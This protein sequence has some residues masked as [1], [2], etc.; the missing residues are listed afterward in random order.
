MEDLIKLKT[1][2]DLIV[3]GLYEKER[4]KKKGEYFYSK[5]LIHGINLFQSL[6]YKYNPEG[7]D[8]GKMHEQSFITEYA[9]RP[10]AEW[11]QGWK[12]KENLKLED[13]SFYYMD[14]LVGDSGF[15]T[16]VEKCKLSY[17]DL[18]IILWDETR[19]QEKLLQPETQGA[20]RYWFENT[21]VFDQQFELSYS[22]AVNSWAKHKYIP[23]IHTR[24]YIHERLGY[25][26]GCDELAKKRNDEVGRFVNR[27]EALSRAYKDI[28]ALGFSSSAKE[29]EDKIAKDIESIR[30]WLALLVA[31]KEAIKDGGSTKFTIQPLGL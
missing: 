15:H 20:Y 6:N 10:V 27:L 8:F 31:E 26:L 22:K 30:K 19:L 13:Q 3:T 28:L 24:G 9:M 2:M 4:Q 1:A 14:A 5:R 18:E 7:F 17:P 11:F 21:V 12:N 29:L 23:E 25:F 16:L